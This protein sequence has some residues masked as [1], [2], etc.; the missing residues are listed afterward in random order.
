MNKIL[1]RNSIEDQTPENYSEILMVKQ[2]LNL[3][4]K[5]NLKG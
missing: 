3:N 2:D 1:I 4:T 5:E